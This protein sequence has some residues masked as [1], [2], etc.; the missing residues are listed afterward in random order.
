MDCG[1]LHTALEV[2]GAVALL[3][4]VVCLLR[5]LASAFMPGGRS[6][7]AQGVGRWAVVTGAS[8]GIGKEFCLELARNGFNIVLMSRTQKKLDDLAAQLRNASKVE[9][10][11]VPVDFGAPPAEYA[12]RIRQELA[13]L[14]VDVLVNNVGVSFEYPEVFLETPEELDSRMININ[15]QSM[16][17]MCRIVLPGMVERKKGYVINV[18]SFSG[19]LPVPM[20]STYSSSKAFVDF[21]TQCLQEEYKKS[22]IVFKCITPMFVATEMAKMRPST[23]VPKPSVVAKGT[24][25]RL[26]SSSV[27]FSPYWAHTLMAGIVGA[28]PR[29]K[30]IPYLCQQNAATRKRA[31]RKKER[32]AAEAAKAKSQ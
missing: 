19:N 21:W 30:A 22:K 29:W 17:C 31:L 14:N 25:S 2:A 15:I 18:G 9:A 16:L 11:V 8:D 26:S 6:L 28:M 23:T 10:K 3:W 5:F 1:C 32:I 7:K 27:T 24:L 20:L 4:G 12:D 13:G